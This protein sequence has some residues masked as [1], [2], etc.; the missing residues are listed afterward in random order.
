MSYV[1][2]R[3][4]MILIDLSLPNGDGIQLACR[5]RLP[6]AA[7]AWPFALFWTPPLDAAETLFKS[8]GIPR[9]IVIHH[10]VSTLKIDAFA[11]GVGG[12]QHLHL[13]VVLE[14]LLRLHALLA[15]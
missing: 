13:G 1:T 14:G 12:Q 6:G 9:Q 4:E 7:P 3:P 5:L 8:V 15:P 10:Q 11:C 2:V